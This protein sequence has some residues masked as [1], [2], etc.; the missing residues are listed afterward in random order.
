M[1]LD[2]LLVEGFL[3]KPL[4]ALV[5]AGG[6]KLESSGASLRVMPEVLVVKGLSEPD[7]QVIVAPRRPQADL[8]YLRPGH[9]ASHRGRSC[10]QL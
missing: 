8:S 3:V 10:A 1:A 4:K 5:D 6:R 9:R 2:Q 7:A